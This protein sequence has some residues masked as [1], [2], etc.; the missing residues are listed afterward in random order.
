VSNVRLRFVQAWVDR[1]GRAHHYFRRAGFPLVRLPGLPGSSEFMAAYEMAMSQPAKP[2]GMNRS[3]PG[4]VSATIAAY[5]DSTLYFG[6][7]AAGTQALQR[8]VLERFRAQYGEHPINNMPAEFISA[9]L[10]KQKPHA[11]RNWLKTLRA[12]CAFAKDTGLMKSDPTN[13]VMLRKLT[14]AERQGHHSWTDDEVAQYE[15]HW[16]IGSKARLALAL[17]VYTG[18]RRGDVIRIGR[19]HLKDGAVIV[20][21]QK[22]GA[23]LTIPLHPELA[24]II[25]ATPCAHLTLLT[26]KTGKPYAA[27]DFSEQ[28]RKWCN[29]A[30]LPARCTFHGLRKHA[31]T[32]LADAGATAHEIAAISGHRSLKEVERYTRAANQKALARSGMDRIANKTVKPDDPEVSKL[33]ISAAKKSLA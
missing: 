8:S 13:D 10:A 5:F 17:A 23:E 31:L 19:Q 33:A 9:L 26:T 21:Q 32:A 30:G 14:V 22:T 18:Q 6:S 25:A 27:H 15:A 29:A 24:S 7:R 1:D 4:S 20:K 28:F 16:P 11:A 2:I 12:L 3:K